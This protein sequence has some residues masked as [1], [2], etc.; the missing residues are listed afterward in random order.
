MPPLLKMS[1]WNLVFDIS[2]DGVSMHTFYRKIKNYIATIIAIK[3]TDGNVF[4]G[5]TFSEWK[6]SKYF[7]GTG[8]SFLYSFTVQLL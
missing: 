5:F 7:Y 3:D 6:Y 2:S 4:G 8:E 1:M